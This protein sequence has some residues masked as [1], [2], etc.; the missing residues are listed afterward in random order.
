MSSAE[1]DV[2]C[3]AWLQRLINAASAAG[4]KIPP[5]SD[6]WKAIEAPAAAAEPY[7]LV[8]PASLPPTPVLSTSSACLPP[9]STSSASRRTPIG[10]PKQT[11]L[12]FAPATKEDKEH[13][14]EQ[15]QERQQ[16][17]REQDRANAPKDIIP[18]KRN[19]NKALMNRATAVTSVSAIGDVADLLQPTTQGWRKSRNG[20]QG[21][22]VKNAPSNGCIGVLARYPEVLNEIVTTLRGLRTAGYV[23]NVPIACSFMIA[24]I[25]KHNPI[26]F[27]DFKCSEKFV[28]SFLESVLDWSLRKATWAAK[29]IPDNAGEL[30]ERTFFRLVYAIESEHIPTSLIWSGKSKL[31]LPKETA[32]GYQ[33]AKVYGFQF[34][35]ATSEKKTS[36]FSTQ[37][38]MRDWITFVLIPYIKAVI[39]VDPDLDKDQKTILYIDIYPVHTSQE[40]RDLGIAPDFF[41]PRMLGFSPDC[42]WDYP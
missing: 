15:G 20:T 21:G 37:S 11:T 10:N 13:E 32:D 16:R 12:Q 17:K 31:S 41:S 24:I 27:N 14:R 5:C 23:V 36:H 33:Q 42:S 29:H 6:K 38:T 30:C 4:A 8:I 35:F 39:E 2:F 34:S 40:F 18:N 3:Q 1:R 22:V 28:R 26:I 7:V 19:A 9:P 25:Q